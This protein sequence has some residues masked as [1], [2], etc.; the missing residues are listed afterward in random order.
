MSSLRAVVDDL[1][2]ATS[3]LQAQI[4]TLQAQVSALA[5]AAAGPRRLATDW[6]FTRFGTADAYDIAAKNGAGAGSPH[7]N[8]T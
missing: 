1:E 3:T 7:G 6:T 2:N 5:S 4:A 8:T